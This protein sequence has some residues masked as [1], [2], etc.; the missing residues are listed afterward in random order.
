MATIKDVAACAGVSVTTV[1]RVLNKR[2]YISK[3][4]YEKVNRAMEE[5]DYQPNELARN[6][7]RQKTNTI[8]VL[9]PDV[10]HPFFAEVVKIIE[11]YLYEKG[12][13]I[14]LCNAVGDG[15]REQEY[16][17]MLRQSK[18]DG[19]IIGTHML[20]TS[21]YESIN[22]PVVALDILLGKKIPTVCADHEQG[23]LLAAQEFI[24]CGCRYVLNISGNLDIMTPSLTRHSTF[25]KELTAHGITCISAC[26]KQEFNRRTYYNEIL[27]IIRQHPC[28]DG[29]FSTDLVA[30]NAMKVLRKL[31]R[32]IP[33]DVVVVGYDGV[34]SAG[35]SY[36]ELTHVKQPLEKIA[37]TCVDIL[38][39]KIN[40]EA[41][42]DNFVLKDVELIRGGTS[43]CVL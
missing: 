40:G 37:K 7:Y 25:E 22:L 9:I 3:E 28:A 24:R 17:T 42:S 27:D 5:L 35:L 6:L 11:L 21:S 43:R 39:K 20:E 13:K 38:L 33:D 12:Y 1:S 29:F 23:G 15:I 30:L 41:V 26:L 36:P 4:V 2:G 10:S 19:I 14:L 32:Q 31:G 16:L 8:G 18:V 34:E